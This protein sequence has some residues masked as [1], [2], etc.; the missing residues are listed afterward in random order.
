MRCLCSSF[1]RWAL[2]R[3]GEPQG[4]DP[5]GQGTTNG[6]HCSL[7]TLV[8]K[9]CVNHPG[10]EPDWSSFSHMSIL[11]QSL[12]LG[13]SHVTATCPKP[14]GLWRK[15][16]AYGD[17]QLPSTLTTPLKEKGERL[18]VVQQMLAVGKAPH[19][20]SGVLGRE[21]RARPGGVAAAGRGC[22]WPSATEMFLDFARHRRAPRSQGRRAQ[23]A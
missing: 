12:W 11:D 1:C 5:K 22:A 21:A 19:R 23:A 16:R 17:W 9:V 6:C 2:P 15:R 13:L 20:P 7:E 4:G 10:E 14:S 3:P 18:T 8:F